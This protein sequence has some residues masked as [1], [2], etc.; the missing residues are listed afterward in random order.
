M[1]INMTT[2]KV[3]EA[4]EKEGLPV[5]YSQKN[6]KVMTGAKGFVAGYAIFLYGDHTQG[7]SLSVW[8][9]RADADAFFGSPEYAKMVGEVIHHIL[10]K[11]DRQ[12][13]DVALDMK[14]VARG[15]A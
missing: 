11:P 2:A 1:W 9:S 14:K 7:C 12:G 3:S 15:E 5:L 10:G 8:E 4:Y 13:W 6:M